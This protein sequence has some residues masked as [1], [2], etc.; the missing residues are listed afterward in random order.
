MKKKLITNYYIFE[1]T[2]YTIM[3][4]YKLNA[5]AYYYLNNIINN[6]KKKKTK[7]VANGKYEIRNETL[8]KKMP[9]FSK[10]KLNFNKK[11]KKYKFS[12]YFF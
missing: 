3:Q 7:K 8:I 10:K 6:C 2:Y 1:K 4:I 5:F 12:K 11:F 9:N